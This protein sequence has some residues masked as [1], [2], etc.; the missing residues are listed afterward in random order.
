MHIG[1]DIE[2]QSSDSG[3]LKCVLLCPDYQNSRQEIYNYLLIHF[4]S[5]ICISAACS[6]EA[7]LPD[8]A[9]D[10]LFTTIPVQKEYPH[11][12]MIPPLKKAMDLKQIFDGSEKAAYPL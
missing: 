11:M 9:I 5:E 10:L 3:K 1:A 7:Q 2:R 12:L 8:T 4:D 6:Y